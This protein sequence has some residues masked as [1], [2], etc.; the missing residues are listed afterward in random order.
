MLLCKDSTYFLG[1]FAYYSKNNDAYCKV[2]LAHITIL[3]ELNECIIILRTL[4][5][6]ELPAVTSS[7]V[8][9]ELPV[10][11]LRSQVL[12]IMQKSLQS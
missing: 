1:L 2:N 12:V 11:F 5:N 4:W 8:M 9:K 10:P 6:L 7:P 3:I